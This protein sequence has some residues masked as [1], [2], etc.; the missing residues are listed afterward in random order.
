MP[1]MRF[2]DFPELFQ[3]VRVTASPVNSP[4]LQ[5]RAGAFLLRLLGA[6]AH[7]YL[8]ARQLAD[9][10]RALPLSVPGLRVEVAVS[11]F[12]RVLD[13]AEFDRVLFALSGPE[14]KRVVRRLGWLNLWNPMRPDGDYVL[15]LRVWEERMMATLLAQL[16]VVEP[17]E[18]VMGV[19][20][21]GG[22]DFNRIA[23]WR[24][25]TTWIDETPDHGVL[26]LHF[27]SYE[28][29]CRPDMALRKALCRHVL[30]FC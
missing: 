9:I 12:P 22:P 28:R 1:E 27:S 19:G 24:L 25:P 18:T 15:D 7:S 23:G 8:S 30:T 20:G 29:G 26:R 16:A 3:P 17:G 10:V 4:A 13:L 5:L 14:R 21:R 2:R 11:L 6:L